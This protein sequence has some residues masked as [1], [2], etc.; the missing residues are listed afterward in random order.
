MIE[1]VAAVPP[2]PFPA[3]LPDR[4][5]VGATVRVAEAVLGEAAD[6]G[7]LRLVPALTAISSQSAGMRSREGSD[8]SVRPSGCSRRGVLRSPQRTRGPLAL[9]R[10]ANTASC[11]RIFASSATG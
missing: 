1:A 3:D 5:P 4:E 2:G 6:Q 11:V 7:E 8:S 9:A 10:C